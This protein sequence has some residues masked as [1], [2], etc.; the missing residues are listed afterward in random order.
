EYE[1]YTPVDVCSGVVRVRCDQDWGRRGGV[2]YRREI[3]CRVRRNAAEVVAS[4]VLDHA[5]REGHVV[6]GAPILRDRWKDEHAVI[7]EGD[8]VC[9]RNRDRFDETSIGSTMNLDITT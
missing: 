1:A 4:V 8:M 7:I 9:V 5:R 3:E 6:L 2:A